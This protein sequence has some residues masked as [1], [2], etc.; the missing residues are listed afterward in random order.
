ME[1]ETIR[2]H[3][4]ARGELVEGEESVAVRVQGFEHVL[5]LLRA[6]R[7]PPVQPL[8]NNTEHS[9][10]R[11]KQSL[12]DANESVAITTASLGCHLSCGCNGSRSVNLPTVDGTHQH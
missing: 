10:I 1:V 11:Q 3:T 6:E 2:R 9:C 5:Q 12:R 7:E 4:K 8:V